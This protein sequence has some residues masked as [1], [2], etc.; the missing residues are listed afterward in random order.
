MERFRSIN[1]VNKALTETANTLEP[2][3]MDFQ[4]FT[5]PTDSDSVEPSKR[6]LVLNP[7]E[8]NIL[9]PLV[10]FEYLTPEAK[11]LI[12]EHTGLHTNPAKLTRRV[13][14]SDGKN[15]YRLPTHFFHLNY[16]F[17]PKLQKLLKLLSF[18][19]KI[20]V[21]THDESVYRFAGKAS[22]E[23]YLTSWLSAKFPGLTLDLRKADDFDF[24]ITSVTERNSWSHPH[25]YYN[26]RSQPAIEVGTLYY[27][28]SNGIRYCMGP[29][30]QGSTPH[31]EAL[32]IFPKLLD[33]VGFTISEKDVKWQP[34]ELADNGTVLYNHREFH[35][36]RVTTLFSSVLN[37]DT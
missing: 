13:Y 33:L 15:I 8:R 24:F 32:K 26:Y 12:S 16:N 17:E 19:L 31:K 10:L 28:A 1:S 6:D 22:W 35:L 20:A 9:D 27:A 25:F 29:Y 37:S 18:N 3:N 30:G 14:A 4:F 21:M 36:S 7:Y 2:L 5:W 23:D 11:Q 34:L